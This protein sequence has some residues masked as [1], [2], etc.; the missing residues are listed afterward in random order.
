MVRWLAGGCV[1]VFTLCSAPLAAQEP[2]WVLKSPANSPPARTHQA[3]A[4]DAARGHV[5]LFD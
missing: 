1:V 5:V 3:M 4:Y 2:N